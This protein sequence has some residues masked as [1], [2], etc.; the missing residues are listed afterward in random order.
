[1]VITLEPQVT[2]ALETRHNVTPSNEYSEFISFWIDWFDLPASKT[3][4]QVIPCRAVL[5]HPFFGLLTSVHIYRKDHRCDTL[6]VYWPSH[7]FTF[8][9]H[10]FIGMGTSLIMYIKV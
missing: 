5:N 4:L 6:G 8:Y 1:M 3:L 7:V 2:K 9:F 10:L